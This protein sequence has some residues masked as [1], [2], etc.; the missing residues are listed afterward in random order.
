MKTRRR[1]LETLKS[2]YGL[3]FISPWLI[4][5][6]CFFI[7]PIFHS[8]YLSFAT[9]E[10]NDDGIYTSFVGLENYVKILLRDPDYLDDLVVVFSDMLVSLPFILIISIILALLL[11]GSFKGK[12][13]FRGMY[14]LP[15]IFASGPV[16]TLFLAAG[17]NNATATA[18]S[19]AVAFGMIDMREILSGLSLPTFMETYISDALSNIFLL[20]WQSGIQTILILAGLQSIP[21][22][23]YEVSKVEGASAWEEFW[24]ITMPMLMR[25]MILVVIFTVIELITKDGNV[26]VKKSYNQF[27]LVE[28]GT[29][30]AMLWFYFIFVIIFVSILYL[31]YD[32]V[33]V[34]KW[35]D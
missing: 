26:V 32:K 14:F 17:N 18:V 35:G 7:Y 34:K 30:S 6:A 22:L 19:D 3:F 8:I 15:V 13:F 4:G 23:L 12:V 27:Q 1:G 25:T 28:Y 16:L 11:N 31:I 24:Y 21:D 9:L 20:V 33:F 5:L 2:R 10:L 29:G